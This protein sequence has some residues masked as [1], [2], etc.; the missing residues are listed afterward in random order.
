MCIYI[1][2]KRFAQ[3]LLILRR[4]QRDIITN[5]PLFFTDFNKTLIL[6]SDSLKTLKYQISQKSIQ[7]EP[8]CSM[9]TDRQTRQN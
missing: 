9:Q 1:V 7:W 6:P 2:S 4:S 8:R 3:T 5:V